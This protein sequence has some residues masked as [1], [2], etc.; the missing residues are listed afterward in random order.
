MYNLTIKCYQTCKT[1]SKVWTE[2]FEGFPHFATKN[3]ETGTLQWLG[4]GYYFWTDSKTNAKWWGENR[5]KAPYCITSYSVNVSS[6]KL[7]DLSGN[8]EQIEYFLELRD[9][10]LKIY[11]NYS[12]SKKYV[13]PTVDIMIDFFRE[14]HRDTF[15]KFEAIKMHHNIY[16]KTYKPIKISQKSQE[17]FQG[18]PRIQLCVFLEKE[19]DIKDKSP[20]YPDAY[21]DSIS[22]LL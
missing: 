6:E 7:L 11:R 21:C 13:V 12:K 4:D 2:L 1:N 18:L 9:T 14:H 8:A 17:F 10:F 19:D 5:L 20:S 15:F 3:S 16:D 22:N